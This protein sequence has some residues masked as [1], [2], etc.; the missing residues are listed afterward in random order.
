MLSRAL[1]SLRATERK[2]KKQAVSRA[3]TV[4][5]LGEVP[6]LEWAEARRLAPVR[7]AVASI[8]ARSEAAD[9]R[10]A[11]RR[12]GLCAFLEAEGLLPPGVGGGAPTQVHTSEGIS[13]RTEA[14]VDGGE[15]RGRKSPGLRRKVQGPPPLSSGDR[16]EPKGGDGG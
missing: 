9:A 5:A 15:G 3:P 14:K 8:L 6:L 13:S 16:R 1:L 4:K 12:G 2:H 7:E 10:R 11:S